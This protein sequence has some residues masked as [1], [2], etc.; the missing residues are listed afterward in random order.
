MK[1]IILY[2]TF[3]G[4]SR[5]EAQ[6]IADSIENAVVCEVK[7][8]K[9]YNIFTAFISGCPKAMKR[10]ASDI[11]EIEYNLNDYDKIILVA[12][13]WAGF[14][15]PAFNSMVELLPAGKEVELFICSGGGE[16]PKSKDGTCQMII[17][18]KCK[19]VDYHDVR[20]SK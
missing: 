1:T 13:V 15:V 18:K 3:G 9:K 12:P 6:R 17:D 7:Q 16:T 10:S 11:K 2:Y 20:T 8:K 19:L 5:K 14:P 4:S